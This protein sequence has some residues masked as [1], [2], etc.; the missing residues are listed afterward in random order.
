LDGG[1]VALYSGG[2]AVEDV[3]RLRLDEGAMVR[4]NSASRFGGGLHLLGGANATLLEGGVNDNTASLRG[5]GIYLDGPGTDLR[6][7]TFGQSRVTVDGN[8]AGLAAFSTG[9]GYGGAI[10]SARARV[11]ADT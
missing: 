2:E 5:G 6:I 1:G 10:Y 7:Q 11:L 9:N 4:D 3:A 8:T